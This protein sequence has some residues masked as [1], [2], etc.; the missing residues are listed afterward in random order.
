VTARQT[1]A[2][3][4]VLTYHCTPGMR[5]RL[6]EHPDW[7]TKIEDDPLHLLEIIMSCVHDPVRAQCQLVTQAD[8]ITTLL[9]CKQGTYPNEESL[10]DWSKQFK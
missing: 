5:Q 6:G 9:T 3:S 2:F 7:K 10:L 4:V 8:F 1:K